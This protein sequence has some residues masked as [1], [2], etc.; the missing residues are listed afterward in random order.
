MLEAL[1]SY[2]AIRYTGSGLDSVTLFLW[3][4]VFTLELD[5]PTLEYTSRR[6]RYVMIR[7]SNAGLTWLDYFR[8]NIWPSFLLSFFLFFFLL[9]SLISSMRSFSASHARVSVSELKEMK[10]ITE[11]VHM[12][13]HTYIWYVQYMYWCMICR[14]T[15]TSY[16]GD[17]TLSTFV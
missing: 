12:W 3:I 5:R 15:A 10:R 16:F 2:R 1:P 14:D 11:Y 13:L 6:V 17:P 8:S 9:I 7:E 4:S